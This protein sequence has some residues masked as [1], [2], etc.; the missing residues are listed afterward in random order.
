MTIGAD[1][2]RIILNAD[3]IDR[4]V[5]RPD[6][7]EV[8]GCSDVASSVMRVGTAQDL[9]HNMQLLKVCPLAGPVDATFDYPRPCE[10]P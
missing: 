10:S 1:K 7:H 2:T 9:L 5:D 4:I 8:W 6:R 3:R